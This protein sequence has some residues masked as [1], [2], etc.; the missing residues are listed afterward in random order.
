MI[1]YNNMEVYFSNIR[2]FVKIIVELTF[3]SLNEERKESKVGGREKMG[4]GYFIF[5]ACLALLA[6]GV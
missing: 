6:R 4:K 3:K 5:L 2:N 1:I